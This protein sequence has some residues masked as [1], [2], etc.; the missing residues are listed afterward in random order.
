MDSGTT[1]NASV[2][3]NTFSHALLTLTSTNHVEKR[4]QLTTLSS[5]R[6][7]LHALLPTLTAEHVLTPL[8]SNDQIIP[9]R[10]PFPYIATFP[11]VVPYLTH[12]YEKEDTDT[13][14]NFYIM[15]RF[16]HH[17]DSG[18]LY[19]L[20]LHYHSIFSATLDALRNPSNDNHYHHNH[21]QSSS[22]F[23]SGSSKN[24]TSLSYSEDRG[25]RLLD[26]G[27]SWVSHYPDDIEY[28]KV[29]GIGMN[30]HE[31]QR[32]GQLDNYIVYNLNTNNTTED[33]N[34]DGDENKNKLK[35]SDDDEEGEGYDYGTKLDHKISRAIDNPKY[36]EEETETEDLSSKPKPALSCIH[37]FDVITCALTIQY[38]QN[39]I[40]LLTKLR[41]YLQQKGR[42]IISFSN[43]MFPTKAVKI[44]KECYSSFQAEDAGSTV[45]S[46]SSSSSSS[47]P[48][49][50]PNLHYQH[51]YIVSSYLYYSGYRNI[52]TFD[53]SPSDY[54]DPL[55]IVQAFAE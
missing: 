15:P 36:A 30:E 18:A 16:V 11:L 32:N 5:A 12:D 13:D 44:W 19:S 24:N 52:Q 9:D 28:D 37:Y 26:I 10:L 25:L 17:V 46:S 29:I 53:L 27:A 47:S 23:V 35:K 3:S 33:D 43:R 41:E 34:K 14:A 49:V 8:D 55:Y 22:S 50:I 31:L 20:T 40:G 4:N 51:I 6:S 38:L 7:Y 48:H 42:I 21:N 39:P 1:N 2:E 54:T 45:F